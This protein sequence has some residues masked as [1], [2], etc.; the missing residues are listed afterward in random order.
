MEKLGMR[1]E[2]VL[3]SHTFARDGTRADL[4]RYGLLREEWEAEAD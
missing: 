4:V 2:G 3:R 1:R